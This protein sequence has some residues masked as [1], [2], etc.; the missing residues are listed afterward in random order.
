M[1]VMT[2]LRGYGD[3]SKPPD[4]LFRRRAACARGHS[5]EERRAGQ[6]AT[7]MTTAGAILDAGNRSFDSSE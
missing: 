1:D 4:D 7:R 2:D 5:A 6:M 3:S